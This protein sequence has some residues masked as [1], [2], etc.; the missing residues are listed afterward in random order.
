M[1]ES[2]IG[3][4]KAGPRECKRFNGFSQRFMDTRVVKRKERVF[5]WRGVVSRARRGHVG[6]V[7]RGSPLL[8]TEENK[9]A[10]VP[11][12]VRILLPKK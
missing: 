7:A 2:Y 6:L 1:A 12:T 8:S 10:R 5:M 9:H 4:E 11:Q 3:K